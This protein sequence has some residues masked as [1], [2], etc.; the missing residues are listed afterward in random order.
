MGSQQGSQGGRE[1]A[2][3]WNSGSR[4]A[5]SSPPSSPVAAAP[6]SPPTSGLAIA[7]LVCGI[8]GVLT[9][10]LTSIVGLV[11]GLIALSQVSRSKGKLGGQGLAIAGT[12]CS[13]ATILLG[14]IMGA[15]GVAVMM[16]ALANARAEARGAVCWNNLRQIGLGMAMYTTDH[17]DAWPDSLEDLVTAGYFDSDEVFTCPVQ[18]DSEDFGEDSVS[19]YEYRKPPAGAG[20]SCMVVYDRQ[21][22]HRGGRNVLFVDAHIEWLPE[23][24]FQ[25]RLA[26]QESAA[27]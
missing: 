20:E 24:E 11:L 5:G 18:L 22:A 27:Q 14:L 1:P 26:E 19:G 2:D 13:G 7:S 4:Q 9:C 15:M 23:E 10:G 25:R 3:S 21:P 8:L 16:P 12:I 6:V 17:E